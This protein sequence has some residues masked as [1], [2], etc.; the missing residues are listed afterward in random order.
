MH[1][2]LQQFSDLPVYRF[3]G[4]LHSN[5]LSSTSCGVRVCTLCFRHVC[6]I[7]G[8][9][10]VLVQQPFASNYGDRFLNSDI[11][12]GHLSHL[13]SFDTFVATKLG[14]LIIIQMC[15]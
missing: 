15:C 10:K 5:Q 2:H 13:H 9:M 14:V 8:E 6:D 3:Q 4:N 7:G 1:I 12:L 11:I